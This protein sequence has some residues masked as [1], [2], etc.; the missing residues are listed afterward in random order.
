MKITREEVEHVATLAR[1][2]LT[3]EQFDLFGEQMNDILLY[4]EKLA[5]LDTAGLPGTNH[6]TATVNAFR[7]DEVKPSLDREKAL[8]NAPASNGE[9]IVVPKVI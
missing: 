9:S 8:A 5:K 4:M 2:K 3:P 6:A 1:L 7:E